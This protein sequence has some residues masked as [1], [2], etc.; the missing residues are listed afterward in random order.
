MQTQT[1]LPANESKQDLLPLLE[2][3][4]PKGPKPLSSQRQRK[5]G[6]LR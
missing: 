6:M 4:M 5:Q 1:R 2:V 3:G